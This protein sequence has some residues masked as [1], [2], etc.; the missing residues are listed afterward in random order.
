[1]PR[2]NIFSTLSKYSASDENYLTESFVFVVNTLLQLE[3]NTAIEF[4]NNLCA[5]NGEFF[6]S[7][8]EEVCVST[9]E[10]TEEGTPD[11]KISS[12]DKLIY[13]EVKHKAGL[14]PHQIKRYRKEVTQYPVRIQRVILLAQ[15]PIDFPDGE[16]KPHR[17]I[18]WYE[19]YDWL[20]NARDKSHDSVVIY[21]I[22]HLMSFLEGKG[23]VIKAIGSEYINGMN[24]LNSFMNMIQSAIE[25]AGIRL[26]KGYPRSAGWNFK[27]YWMEDKKYWC[28]IH[29]GSPTVITFELTGKDD[30]NP[31]DTG[32]ENFELREGK[33]RLWFRLPLQDIKFFD[34]NR[35]EQLKTITDFV[36]GSY[37]EA[38][39]MRKNS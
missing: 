10:V 39:K 36:K 22:D 2:N 27:G 14:G 18:H 8:N 30:Y 24:S 13:I 12:P 16:E 11:I 25:A 23:M 37:S 1:M 35:D 32:E 20:V 31:N 4:L 15:Y 38:R 34:M 3:H 28:G 19:V 9:Q 29:F 7:T 5:E 33:K 21:L 17:H 6:F 26:F